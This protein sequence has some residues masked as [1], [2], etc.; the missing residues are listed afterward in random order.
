[1]LKPALAF[2]AASVLLTACGNN[3]RTEA[4]VEGPVVSAPESPVNPAVDTQ[5]ASGGAALTPGA[6]SFTEAQARAAIEKQGYVVSGALT[7]DAQGIWK[8]QAARSGEPAAMV[9][10]DYKGVV[11]AQ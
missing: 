6:N 8:A 2:A 9:S 3:D 11:S 5:G 1:M 7:Q 10:V 4:P